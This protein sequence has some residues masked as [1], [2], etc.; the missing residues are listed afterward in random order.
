MFNIFCSVKN[1]EKACY[2][3]LKS[4]ANKEI[5]E[6]EKVEEKIFIGCMWQESKKVES[7]F[8]VV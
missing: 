2:L 8:A 5:S 4:K 6:E 1:S 3:G 7:E